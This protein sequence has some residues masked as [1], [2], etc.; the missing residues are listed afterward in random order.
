MFVIVVGIFWVIGLMGWVGITYTMISVAIMPLM[1]GINI[2]YA[3]H[4]LSRYALIMMTGGVL[5]RFA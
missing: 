1:L 5:Y 3:I 4:I 2:A